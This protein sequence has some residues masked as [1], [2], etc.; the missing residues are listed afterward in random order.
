[1]NISAQI[2][3][4]ISWQGILQDGS[5]NPLN[6]NYNLTVK[7][8]D[9][10]SGGAA[11][12]SETHSNI[13][14]ADGLVNLSLGS[15]TPFGLDFNKQFWLEITVG[16]GTPLPRIKLSS[17]PYAL[18]SKTAESI[19][20]SIT[21]TDPVFS[22]SPASGILNPDIANWNT[23]HTW[24]DHSTEGY[25]TEYTETDPIFSSSASSG[26]T[27]TNITNW[28]T[29][30]SW[31][32]H[33]TEGYLKSFTELDPTWSGTADQTS[34]IG[35]TG[36]VGIGTT[37]PSALLHTSGTGT[38]EGNVLHVGEFKESAA[39]DPP[40][41]GAGTRMMWYPDKA[42]FRVGRVNGTQWDRD[43]IGIYSVAM[44]YKT[45]AGQESSTAIGGE[46]TASGYRSTAIGNGSTA[47]GASSTAFGCNTLASGGASTAMG[48]STTASGNLSFATGNGST[49]SGGFSFAMGFESTAS[50]DHSMA[51][52]TLSTASGERSIAMGDHSNA[53]GWYSTAIGTYLTAPSSYETVIGR[54]NTDYTPEDIIAWNTNDRL[55]VIGNGIQNS[56][57]RDAMVVLKSGNTGI[58]TSTPTA[59]F[60][61]RGTS[62]GGGNVLFA[63]LQKST[64]GDPPISGA[65]TRM[66]WY[67]DKAAF[68]AG[69]VVS[70]QWNKEN[71]G[72]NSTA[73]GYN[74][75][76]SG[77]YSTAIGYKTTASGS[78]STAMGGNTT[79]KSFTE[80][81]I[82]NWNTNYTPVS[83]MEWNA[84]DRLFVIGNGT[85]ENLRNDAM[86]VLKNGYTGLGTSA[87][88]ALLH[89][90]GTGIGE[91]NVLFAGEYKG[92]DPGDPPVT[93]AGTRM[94]WYPDKGAFRA[95]Y[96]DGTQWDKDSIGDYSVAMGSY[97]KA[98][99]YS[100]IALGNSS[101]ASGIFS[102]A[103]GSFAKASGY[104]SIALGNTST[105]SGYVS[106]A[107]GYG[108]V[109][110]GWHSTA[111]GYN[112]TA[113]GKYTTVMGGNTTAKS[114][115]ET[116]V[117]RWNT[118]YTPAS[119]IE[120][121][122]NDRLF[123]IGNGTAENLRSDAMVVLK[124]GKTGIG[125][126]A[127]TATLH[128][129]PGNW[130][131]VNT[132]GDVLIGD[133]I[134]KLKISMANSG[135]GAGIA[136]INS[137]ST[138]TFQSVRLGTGG[139]DMLT[140]Q[141]IGVGIGTFNPAALLH[142]NG[143]GT[144]EGN[145]LFAG[146][147]KSTNKGN[148][149]VSGAGT[150]MMWYPDKAA[151]RAG[152]VVGT[153]WDKDSIGDYSV[154]FG[155][156]AIAKSLSAVAI[157]AGNIANAPNSTALGAYT[158]ASGN[159]STAIGYQLNVNSYAATAI[160]RYNVGNGN[161]N[162]WVSTDPIFEIGVGTDQTNKQNAMT[163]LKNGNTGIG[164][165][166]P[167]G[168]SLRVVSSSTGGTNSTG[169]FE[170]TN[171]SGL[172]L[173]ATTNSSDG[174][175]LSIQEGDG[176]SLRC[177]GYDP[178]WFVAMI[179][180]GRQVGINTSAPTQNLDVNGNARFRSI[181]SGAYSGVV[182]RTSDGTLTTAT[183][184][185][186]FKENISTL[187]NSLDRVMQLRGVS[188]TWKSN[189]EYGT[190]IG[191]VAQE[192]EKVVPELSFINPADGFMG[193][194][195]AEM[196]AVLVEAM[197]EQ[198]QLIDTQ[199]DRINELEK[200]LE[201]LIQQYSNK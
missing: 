99:G 9:V 147:Y 102:I 201:L 186:R 49:A 41:T 64:P 189:P 107:M 50:G 200:K 104:S 141:G 139:T 178:N 12:W 22:S 94:M 32:D 54:Y 173:R 169:F 8:F 163:V 174:T 34:S 85:A 75:I 90:N 171:S 27:N 15:I 159:F 19:T 119:E 25:L 60:H 144:G 138:G 108:I 110:S 56:I 158:I 24:G 165:I 16:S 179:V 2:P 180:K 164:T 1:M 168:N 51:T 3:H 112:S 76:A 183:S 23:A 192:F 113:S 36:N 13:V 123:V 142:T 73:M 160:G 181:G 153:E 101:T 146:E 105:A 40:A 61:V 21:E 149:P 125:T 35:R 83:A 150:R 184:D 170:N 7:L 45:K 29:A 133:S 194:N 191:F 116:V 126:T 109:A 120:W 114:S 135:S 86:V 66:M 187:E 196:T 199:N 70:T 148:P 161:S 37:T 82:G 91:G 79:A 129:K 88:T 98:S 130:D 77:D 42:A 80:T 20:G 65:G 137:I 117:G 59:L 157:G 198:Q 132:D 38:G 115:F 78:Y 52:G 33:S 155:Y 4:N 71:I 152:R 121:N 127:P 46:T 195:Y 10:A 63:G 124:N 87:P 111:M 162:S 193:I 18:H 122:A 151:F 30:H 97:T 84:N 134:H 167:A 100:S 6:G 74:P 68:R 53:S 96:I 136:R 28:N 55:F 166:N 103:L 31:G 44:G 89:T 48:L 145:I 81:V 5:G 175:I 57:R 131:I 143:T 182:N 176:Y 72:I 93:G 190:R 26:I 92:I 62:T 11:L 17:V 128:V 95:G 197:K 14:I 69:Q 39:G 154:A 118:D 140:V 185:I 58:G 188:F 172:A 177:D 156:S 47:S 67:P 106:T 43:S